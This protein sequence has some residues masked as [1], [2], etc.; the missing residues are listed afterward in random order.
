MVVFIRNFFCFSIILSISSCSFFEP[1]IDRYFG[2]KDQL[3]LSNLPSWYINA[4]QNDQQ[5]L[6]GVGEGF[7]AT[8]ANKA[9][10]SN[11]A[12]R[13]YVTVSSRSSSLSQENQF[14][15]NEQSQ[16]NIETETLPISFANYQVIN[17]HNIGNKFYAQI[18]IDK[19]D[20]VSKQLTKLQDLNEKMTVLYANAR[21]QNILVRRN[22]LI[23]ILEYIKEAEVI[24]LILDGL[25]ANRNY[26]T[27]VDKYNFYNRIYD[28][29]LGRIS[30]Y[31]RSDN[32]QIK[33]IVIAALNRQ[34]LTVT[35]TFVNSINSVLL[36]VQT[37]VVTNNIYG[38]NVAN[39]SVFFTNKSYDGKT[40]SSN[41][42]RVSGSSPNE[43]SRYAIGFAVSNFSQKIADDGILKVI[44]VD[45]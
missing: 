8:E 34:D 25:S 39:L 11:L 22:V 26:Q 35:E 37:D 40:L 2:S 16:Q 14:S 23:N 6:Y 29:T 9:A 12:S 19:A 41:I 31:I 36:E 20:F 3:E 43:D 17:S 32:Q 44:G 24:N 38:S 45:K 21:S 42:V 1:Y 5:Y 33:N 13:L 27:N 7:S 10:L 30:F 15:F 4:K 28:E 18:S